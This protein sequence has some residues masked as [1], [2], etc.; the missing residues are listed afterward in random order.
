MEDAAEMVIHHA[1]M[2]SERTVQDERLDIVRP[3]CRHDRHSRAHRIG[4]RAQPGLGGALLR[5]AKR[6]QK[7]VDLGIS[8]RDRL[9]NLS[10]MPMI[11]KGQD[12]MPGLSER[13]AHTEYIGFTRA[14]AGTNQNSGCCSFA[15]NVPAAYLM[16]AIKRGESHIFGR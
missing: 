12:I 11:I 8:E 10:A 3:R 2:R 16:I 14:I 5:I 4:K 6:A 9:A 15:G 1:G 13:S 7:I